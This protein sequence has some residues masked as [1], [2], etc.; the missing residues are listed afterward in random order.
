MSLIQDPENPF[1]FC[2]PWSY[3]RF[4]DVMSKTFSDDDIAEHTRN[5]FNRSSRKT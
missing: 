2:L 3:S 1:I 4:I 5:A